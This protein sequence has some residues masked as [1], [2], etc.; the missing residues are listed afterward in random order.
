MTSNGNVQAE[1]AQQE[2][3]KP[4]P[5]VVKEKKITSQVP[6]AKTTDVKAVSKKESKTE[7]KP[8]K[9]VSLVY[10]MLYFVDGMAGEKN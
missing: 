5:Q 1:A 4:T 2:V 10:F 9:K 6:K 3:N 7:S 8:E